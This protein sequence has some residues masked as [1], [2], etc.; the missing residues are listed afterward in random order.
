V[1]I[2]LVDVA[3]NL[4]SPVRNYWP[5]GQH[6]R[7]SKSCSG[8]MFDVAAVADRALKEALARIQGRRGS[9]IRY[10]RGG[11]SA[12]CLATSRQFSSHWLKVKWSRADELERFLWDGELLAVSFDDVRKPKVLGH[13]DWDA[14]GICYRAVM[15]DIASGI[16]SKTPRLDHLPDLAPQWWNEL[17]ASIARIALRE[18]DR[19]RF[20]DMD[21]GQRLDDVLSLTLRLPLPAWRT[22]HGDMHWANLAAPGFMII[23]W[24][25]WGR[26]PYGLDVARLHVFA[27]SQP[28]ILETLKS[29]FRA[30]MERPEYDI[31]FLFVAAGVIQMFDLYGHYPLLQA[32]VR[33]EVRNVLQRQRIKQFQR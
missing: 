23:D 16:I 8:M 1:K 19:A 6:E 3:Q 24:E 5:D 21:I 4:G 10:G 9:E 30:A 27:T 28:V 29:V 12:G 14:D 7:K 17:S 22:A 11:R 32:A 20:S 25:T 2:D 26:A 13:F 18:T 31:A 15:M 33:T